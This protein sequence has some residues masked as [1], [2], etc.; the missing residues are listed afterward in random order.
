[1]L[2]PR[3]QVTEDAALNDHTGLH[4]G[5]GPYLLLYSRKIDEAN[6]PPEEWPERIRVSKLFWV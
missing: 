5:G 3:N 4:L 2:R 1:M 6:L